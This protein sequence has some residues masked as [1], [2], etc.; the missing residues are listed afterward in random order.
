MVDTGAGRAR[1]QGVDGA[2]SLAGR[3]ISNR[4]QDGSGRCPGGE[5]GVD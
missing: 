5:W 1:R 2:G 3:V 4:I